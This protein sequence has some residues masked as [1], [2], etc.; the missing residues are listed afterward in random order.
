MVKSAILFD[1]TQLHQNLFFLFDVFDNQTINEFINE[2]GYN[3]PRYSVIFLGILSL[4][5]L[6]IYKFSSLKQDFEDSYYLKYREKE[7]INKEYHLYFLF[8]G[9]AIITSELVFEIFS[10]R[11]KTILI[12]NIIFGCTIILFYYILSKVPFLFKN[13]RIIFILFFVVFFIYMSSNILKLSDN[14]FAAI[15]FLIFIFFSYNVIKPIKLY[16]AFITGALLFLFTILFLQSIPTKNTIILINYSLV[17]FTINQIKHIIFN[18][19]KDKLQFTNEIVQ[20]GNSLII[21]CNSRGECIYCSDSIETIL[22]YTPEE[23]MG[24]EYWRLTQD[25]EFQGQKYF[26]NH[27]ENIIYT[28]KL[29]CKNGDYKYIQ[30]K[31]KRLEEDLIIGIGQDITEQYIQKDQYINLIQNASDL[32]FEIN[33]EGYFT[34]VNNYALK[35][36]GYTETEIINKHYNEFVGVD[37]REKTTN[38]YERL[39]EV[40]DDFPIIEIPLIKKN[41]QEIWVSQKVIIKKNE[42]AEIIGYS[43]ISRDITYNKNKENLKSIQIA[44]LNKYNEVVKKLS[45]TNF[46]TFK[47]NADVIN[48]ILKEAITDNDI[49]STSFWVYEVNQIKCKFGYSKVETFTKEKKGLLKREDYPVY[50]EA[51]EAKSQIIISDVLSK[52]ETSEFDHQYLGESS[53]RSLIDSS[54]YINGKLYGIVC[55]ESQIE[56]KWDIDDSNF[57]KTIADIISL[58]IAT[59]LRLKEDK[60]IKEKSELLTAV[61]KCTESLLKNKTL[62]E[63]FEETFEAIGKAS[64]CDRMTYYEKDEVD[65][66]FDQKFYWVKNKG[67]E[68]LETKKRFTEEECSEIISQFNN[69][70]FVQTKTKNL[71]ES[72]LKDWYIEKNIKS[73][74]TLPIYIGN[75]LT[76]GLGLGYSKVSQKMSKDQILIL[77]TLTNN[78]STFLE[79]K[80]KEKLILESEQ[81]F[82]LIVKTVP[83]VVYLSK[84]DKHSSKVYLNEEI[85]NLTGYTKEE[86][87]DNKLSF[88]SLIHPD[89]KEKIIAEQIEYIEN[90]KSIHSKYPIKRKSGE[91][92]WIEEYA[93]VISNETEIEY[94]GGIYFQIEENKDSITS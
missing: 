89:Y 29:K 87:L 53:V 22:G 17:I 23:V 34:F 80:R 3:I 81:R 66:L 51:I 21:A 59:Q 32:I 10:F 31:D 86:F 55:F 39:E 28:R 44:K 16:Y 18:N 54:V 90:K 47:N 64:K 74:I 70:A 35:K 27:D 30:W 19:V 75:K 13:I 65:G 33:N 25:S 12:N 84:F 26:E 15:G 8:L 58:G 61:A 56:K 62:N 41:G 83:G 72:V 92:I 49:T 11:D 68:L 1:I 7:S 67:T 36:L 14:V 71:R 40:L 24:M 46:S 9:I 77:I 91:Y 78:I 42:H 4:S 94:I 82:K 38:F 69:K 50:F 63:M 60:K 37:Y 20:K 57:A 79:N 6:L 52:Y 73:Q 45:T 2:Y 43:G 5:L 48:F 88:L 93:D 85:K 76:G